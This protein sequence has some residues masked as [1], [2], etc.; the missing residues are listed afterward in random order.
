MPLSLKS[1]AGGATY[2]EA[3]TL[4]MVGPRDE[5]MSEIED[6]EEGVVPAVKSVAAKA[7]TQYVRLNRCLFPHG[8]LQYLVEHPKPLIE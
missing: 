7:S 3:S 5:E 1:S 6:D 4:S 2:S 8:S